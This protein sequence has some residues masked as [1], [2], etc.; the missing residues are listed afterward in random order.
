M[1]NGM[2]GL[3]TATEHL[4]RFGDIGDIPIT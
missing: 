3:Y 4:G 2:E 1:H